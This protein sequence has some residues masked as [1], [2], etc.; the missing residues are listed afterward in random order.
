MRLTETTM[1]RLTVDGITKHQRLLHILP[2]IFTEDRV[3]SKES[4]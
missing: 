2:L 4:L 3:V 1:M